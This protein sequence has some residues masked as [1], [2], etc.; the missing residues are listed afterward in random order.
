MR[1]GLPSAHCLCLAVIALAP[2]L[3]A[4]DP[5]RR[6]AAGDDRQA[7]GVR[8]ERVAP[9]PD[10]AAARVRL[11]QWRRLYLDRLSALRRSATL[12]FAELE[13]SSLAT[14]T[15]RCG[16]LLATVAAVDR[17][18]LFPSTEVEIDRVLFG[19]LER[20]RAGAGECLAGRFLS[21]YRLL[22]EA[23]AGLEWVDRRVDRRLSAPVP[24]PG[25][26]P[27]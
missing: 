18:A 2:A 23:R 5:D 4:G 3:Q 16:D 1:G 13:R 9:T 25:L 19:S 17:A 6:G 8:I 22:V 7:P 14:L 24:L 12:L 27:E 20:F 10:A 15:D 26:D 11:R 21:A